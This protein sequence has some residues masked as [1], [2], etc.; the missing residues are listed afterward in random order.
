MAR[1]TTTSM[2]R[3]AKRYVDLVASKL[4]NYDD[5]SLYH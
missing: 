2:C 5:S 3:L 4:I 1:K